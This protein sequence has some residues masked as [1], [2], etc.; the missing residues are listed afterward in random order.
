MATHDQKSST[1]YRIL[2]EHLVLV[3]VLVYALASVPVYFWIVGT[4][5]D[6]GTIEGGIVIASLITGSLMFVPAIMSYLRKKKFSLGYAK[7]EGGDTLTEGPV[8]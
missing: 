7:A 6:A 3:S 2:D 8:E 5:G 4:V 1:A